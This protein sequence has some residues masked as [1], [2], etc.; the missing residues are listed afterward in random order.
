MIFNVEH[1]VLSATA[2]TLK[3]LL[4][5]KTFEQARKVLHITKIS[6]AT[7]FAKNYEN[8]FTNK[9]IIANKKGYSFFETQ[10]ISINNFD[11][12]PSSAVHKHTTDKSMQQKMILLGRK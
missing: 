6:L 10:C 9:K 11:S 2:A 7:F 5:C 1:H 3:L 12:R 8:W 4:N